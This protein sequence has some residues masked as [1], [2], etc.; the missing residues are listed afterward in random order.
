MINIWEPRYKDKTVLVM[1]SR[2]APGEDAEIEIEKGHYAGRYHVS[3]DDIAN[4]ATEWKESKAG[5]T[6]KFTVIPLDKLVKVEAG[7]DLSKTLDEIFG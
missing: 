1:T 7:D 2:L 6:N 5:N 4:C 3:A